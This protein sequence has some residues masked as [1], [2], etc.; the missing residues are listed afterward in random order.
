MMYEDSLPADADLDSPGATRPANVP[1][2]FWD[3]AKGEIRTEALLRAYQEL[4]RRAFGAKAKGV[5]ASPD[6]Y[7]ISHKH[8]SLASS[9][10]VNQRLHQAGFS[11]DQAQLVYDLAHDCLLPILAQTAGLDDNRDG[12]LDHLCQHF[13]GEG[14]WRQIAPQLSAWGKKNLP[15]DAYHV[16][17][18][19]VDGVK[20][21]HRLM[22]SGE[23]AL[24][25]VPGPKD[26]SPDEDQ[27]KKMIQDPRY[28]KSRDPAYIAK[29]Q[30]GF[31][32][33]YGEE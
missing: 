24:G 22:G 1:E 9:P 31:R 12:D 7:Q 20:A 28:W 11:Q 29:V 17:A 25:R 15:S 2:K 6:Q 3:A 13:G 8:P 33:L 30:A 32:R 10:E 23:P 19:S 5:P 4:E 27:L 26:D 18:S 21:L 16:M 14:R